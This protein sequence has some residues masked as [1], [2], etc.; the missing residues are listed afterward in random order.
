MISEEERKR[1]E[2]EK[3]FQKA[4]MDVSESESEDDH[5]IPAPDDDW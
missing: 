1:E 3:L 2:M 5:G 4:K